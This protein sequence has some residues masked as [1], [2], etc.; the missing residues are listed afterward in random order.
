MAAYLLCVRSFQSKKGT[1]CNTVTLLVSNRFKDWETKTV[2]LE[3]G[4]LL[5]AAHEIPCGTAVHCAWSFSGDL[6]NLEP[7]LDTT[8][9]DLPVMK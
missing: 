4:R 7:D 5:K 8:P 6:E 3:E 1:N 9:L 2:F